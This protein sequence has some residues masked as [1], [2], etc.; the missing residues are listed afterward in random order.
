MNTSRVLALLLSA[1][2]FEPAC[3]RPSQ[4]P[5]GT[6]GPPAPVARKTP[7]TDVYHGVSVTDDYRWLENRDDPAVR[8]WSDAENAH[9]RWVLD[10][11]PG[12]DVIRE[13]V[14]AIRKIAVPRY[15]SLSFAG[16]TLFA[17]RM[18]PPK[19]Q[20]VLVAM[21]SEEDPESATVVVDPEK[22]DPAGGTSIDWYVPSPDG[23]LVAVS[24]SE[25][26]SERGSAHLFDAATGAEVG[27]VVHRVNYGTALGS[28]AWDLDGRGFYYTRYP[29][30]GERPAADLDFHVQ[31]YHH[32]LG[33]PETADRYELGRNFPRIAEYDLARSPDGRFTLANV[34]NGDGGEFAQYL[35]RPDGR[36]LQLTRFT[37]RI[38]N[39]AFGLDGALY[40]LSRAA[41]PLGGVLKV[42]LEEVVRRGGLDLTRRHVIV[43][44][45]DE[46]VQ[47]TFVSPTTIIP[48]ESLLFVVEAVG[49]PQRVSIYDLDGRYRGRLPIAPVGGV[50]EI[51]H[52]RGRGRNVVLYEPR[53]YVDPPGW[54]RWTSNE[55][56]LVDVARS[57][58]TRPFPVDFRDVEVT[59]LAAVSK[60]GTRVPMN[61]LARKGTKLD[62]HN[63]T[64]L[65]GYGG[66][67]IS[68]TPSFEPIRRLWFDRG[69]VYVVA[70]LRGGGEFGEAWH[71]AG[72]LTRKQ[73]VFDDFIA[74]AEELIRR[75]YA[76]PGTLAIEGASNGGLLMG[77]ALTQRPDLFKAVV[78]HVGIYDM[79]RVELA[80]NGAFNV[81]EFG[82]VK[83]PEQFRALHAYSPYHHVKDGQAC[84]AILFMT[85]ANDARVDPMHSR[86][87]TARL[88]AAGAALV[89][90][91]TSAK[92]G[93]GGGTALDE[94]IAQDVDSLA[95]LFDQLDM[96][97][98]GRQ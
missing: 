70:N 77:A 4:S 19:Q 58:L 1:L 8:A 56:G 69:G 85:G 75:G 48:A 27:E 78:S 22:I 62:G 24:L 66:Y 36:W 96:R 95:F 26:G 86:K 55:G 12:V 21:V 39:A 9:A 80:P 25:G 54:Y 32:Q 7:V 53:S 45:S 50:G 91:R 40:L 16:G 49:G 73:N 89:L 29:R 57:A 63:P 37:D 93:H 51:V 72:N 5:E 82:S 17:L 79:L 41:F 10:R 74:C 15:G 52:L 98:P 90:L 18:E 6:D 11:L 28:L 47:E 23:T 94:R 20:A 83:D 38:V 34:Q 30:E 13:D 92:S 31:V 14:A 43:A 81:P 87:M 71:L 42:P 65:V 68:Q 60:D 33:T 35:R 84:P 59:R 44:A 46:A 64:L 61:V 67:G 2:V 3:R 88:Q 76:S 97:K